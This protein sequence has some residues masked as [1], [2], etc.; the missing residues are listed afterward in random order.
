MSRVISAISLV[1]LMLLNIEVNAT[2]EEWKI[3]KEIFKKLGF[4][5]KAKALALAARGKGVPSLILHCKKSGN[6]YVMADGE[7]KR[8]KINLYFNKDSKQVEFA[9][10]GVGRPPQK[11]EKECKTAGGRL[12]VSAKHA[13]TITNLS[14]Q[15]KKSIKMA[16]LGKYI[17]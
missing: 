9:R 11:A 8:F 12:V 2:Q 10:K 5:E 14:E 6:T 17:E 1:L 16:D 4:K 15:A 7:K 3:A 13:K